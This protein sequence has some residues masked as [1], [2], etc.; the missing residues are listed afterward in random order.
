M[1]FAKIVDIV[2]ANT[3][4]VGQVSYIV[5]LITLLPAQSYQSPQQPPPLHQQKYPHRHPHLMPLLQ[6]LLH[7]IPLLLLYVP[8]LPLLLY[9]PQEMAG[10]PYLMVLLMV[11][12]MGLL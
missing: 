11:R 5:R 3:A 1:E 2:V 4:G 6:L 9:V 10:A 7:V 12:L 8:T